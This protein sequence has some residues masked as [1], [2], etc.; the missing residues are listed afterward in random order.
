MSHFTKPVRFV[1]EWVR[2]QHLLVSNKKSQPL[3]FTSHSLASCC[4]I[5]I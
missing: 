3:C 2:G 5:S 4:A 1:V